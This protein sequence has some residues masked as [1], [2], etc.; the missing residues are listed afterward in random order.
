MNVIDLNGAWTLY[1]FPQGERDVSS[2]GRLDGCGCPRV[3]AEVPGNCA[4]DLSRAGVL[5]EDLFFGDNIRLLREYERCRWWYI[6][7]FRTP[8]WAADRRAVLRFLG[9]DT[10]ARYWLNGTPVGASENMLI[11][12]VFEVTGL[13]APAG[14]PNELAVCLRSAQYEMHDE[15]RYPE[16]APLFGSH[17]RFRMSRHCFGWDI[18]PRAIAPGLWRGV[19]LAEIEENCVTELCFHVE[20][21]QG[22]E[23][24]VRA[25]FKLRAE[26]RFLRNLEIRMTARCG[27]SAAENR[28]K[29]HGCAGNVLLTFGDARLW[30]PR[31]YGEANLYDVTT[32]LLCDGQTIHT[33]RDVIGIRT[34]ELERTET[35]DGEGT[36]QFLF[37]V[38]GEPVLIKGANWVP[39]DAFH[40]R[41]AGR[42]DR[43]LALAADLNC[44]ML[45]CWGGGVYEDDRFYD[46][47]DR[48]GILVWQDFAMACEVTPQDAAFLEAL[49]REAVGVVKRLRNHP[50]L[51]LWCGDNECDEFIFDRGSRPEWNRATRETLPGALMECDPFRPWLP[52][53]PYYAPAVTDRKNL[54]LMPER[55]LWGDRPWC[56]APYYAAH[57]AH[58][59]SETG[60][61]SCPRLSSLRRY[62]DE[63]HFWP[64]GGS[65][66]WITHSTDSTGNPKRVDALVRQAAA[67]FGD[68][69]GSLPEFVAASQICQAE[70]LKYIIESTR[71]KKWR[72]TGVLWW[73]LIDGWPQASE[74]A[75]DYY[76]EKKLAYHY[77]KRV[78]QPVCLMLDEPA[79]GEMALVAGNDSLRAAAGPFRVRDASSGETVLEGPFSAPANQNTVLGYID[80]P[81]GSRRLLL[82]EWELD[83]IRYGNHRLGGEPPFSLPFCLDALG[84][85]CMLPAPFDTAYLTNEL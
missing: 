1:W 40:S 26:D 64:C 22:R 19:E 27:G 47:C 78:Q 16:D 63:Q 31:G 34:V 3:P 69:P 45:R 84:H 70:S 46:L 36:G 25:Y 58:F 77:V 11:P 39:A 20:R 15:Q 38:N 75:V 41:D 2:P 55:H 74:A 14:E 80:E 6:R 21:A 12:H 83:G 71:L 42:Y 23:A 9:V 85:I 44:N 49:R 18:L 81:E 13:L 82:I 50:C 52:S 79:G 32:S 76:F 65:S 51:A 43:M 60:F 54:D 59:V 33:R 53:S 37:R 62:L 56:K 29:V 35:T 66:Q 30:W 48:L 73:N 28:K 61:L 7:S 8:A 57:T 24:G 10:F 4:L 17:L 68:A 67:M 72:R 5:P